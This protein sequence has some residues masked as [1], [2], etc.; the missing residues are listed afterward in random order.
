M[1]SLSNNKEDLEPYLQIGAVVHQKYIVQNISQKGKF[2]RAYSVKDKLYEQNY[3]LIELIFGEVEEVEEDSLKRKTIPDKIIAKDLELLAD[4]KRFFI[5][6]KKIA[7]KYDK[8]STISLFPLNEHE[9]VKLL[10]QVLFCLRSQKVNQQKFSNLART[11]LILLTGENLYNKNNKTWNW[12]R[13]KQISDQRKEVFNRMLGTGEVFKNVDEVLQNLTT[14]F[15]KSQEDAN[16]QGR[17]R[18]IG[19]IFGI[20]L[21]ATGIKLITIFEVPSKSPNGANPTPSLPPLPPSPKGEIEKTFIN[22]YGIVEDNFSLDFAQGELTIKITANGSSDD[23]L[24]ITNTDRIKVN[25]NKIFY[26]SR[27]IGSFNKGQEKKKA[28]N[29]YF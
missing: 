28:F 6:Y 15:I 18:L 11:A 4:D 25:N 12:E 9:V 21:I 23:H 5:F 2:L 14:T 13:S 7:S 1:S 22:P 17:K 24:T 26:H 19:S 10:K 27:E 16:F 3:V 29:C 20:F 8:A